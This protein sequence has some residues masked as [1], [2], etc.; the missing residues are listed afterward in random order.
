MSTDTNQTQNEQPASQPVKM[1]RCNMCRK[2][3]DTVKKFTNQQGNIPMNFCAVCR[4]T[5]FASNFGEVKD[6]D[7][8]IKKE[9]DRRNKEARDRYSNT[10]VAAAAG[11]LVGLCQYP[12]CDVE[13]CKTYMTKTPHPITQQFKARYCKPHLDLMNA[14]SSVLP[15]K[16]GRASE[17]LTRRIMTMNPISISQSAKAYGLPEET[18]KGLFVGICRVLSIKADNIRM[19]PDGGI[20]QVTHTSQLMHR[21]MANKPVTEAPIDRTSYVNVPSAADIQARQ[22]QGG[23]DGK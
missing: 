20:V 7:K 4:K 22:A 18:I 16:I 13:D 12:D 19:S 14:D 17:G 1:L 9:S 3:N 2:K 21:Q 15:F 11:G 10:D 23:D 8:A 5:D 6:S